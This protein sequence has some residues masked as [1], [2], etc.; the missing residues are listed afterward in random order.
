MQDLQIV[1]V[2]Y[3]TYDMLRQF[4]NSVERFYP[5]YL[6]NLFIVDIE[7]NNP[8]EL[9]QYEDYYVITTP[10]NK[11]YAWGC[12]IAAG[13]LDTDYVGFFN[14][15]TAF[16]DS[17]CIQR[18]IE[19][20][21]DP[22]VGAVGPFQKGKNGLVTHGGIFGTN[23]KPEHRGWGKRVKRNPYKDVSECITISGSAYFTR[24]D[25]WQEMTQCDIYQNNFPGAIGGFLPTPLYYEETGYS[26]HIREHG[27]K[28]IYCGEAEMM[29][30]W[31]SSPSSGQ[32]RK[33]KESQSLFR[34][35]MD[36]HGIL[37]D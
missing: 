1:V 23:E 20:F 21:A 19:C 35:F 8:S 34:S 22:S 25:V 28:V 5:E 32:G 10:E 9:K 18:C 14:A 16:I 30:Y 27:Y 17:N 7:S 11:G 15:D 6:D 33:F 31:N 24:R 29:H 36:D 13:G 26:Y 3:H 37:H 12:N 4:V 2:N